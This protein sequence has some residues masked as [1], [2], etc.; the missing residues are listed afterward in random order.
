MGT[1]G[2]DEIIGK[3]GN[4]TFIAGKGDDI[5]TGG[6]GSDM[7]IIEAESGGDIITD[8]A[9]GEN[10]DIVLLTPDLG[11]NSGAEIL[12]AIATTPPPIGEQSSSS[13]LDFGN[14]NS[15]TILHEAPLVE[16][17]FNVLGLA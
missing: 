4:D 15:L 5:L 16:S 12:A 7:F 2:G 8:F 1:D 14:G 9:G 3:A 6:I 13:I 10:N 11:F 17:N